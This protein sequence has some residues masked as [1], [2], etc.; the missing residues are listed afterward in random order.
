MWVNQKGRP[1]SDFH[2]L[3]LCQQYCAS[4]LLNFQTTPLPELRTVLCPAATHLQFIEVVAVL[5]I[6]HHPPKYQQTGSVT[7]EAIGRTT[8][9]D[10]SPHSW[11]EPLVCS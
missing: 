4:P 5:A 8:R 11:D 7:N 6:L 2:T 1:G 10:V 9:R 3:A